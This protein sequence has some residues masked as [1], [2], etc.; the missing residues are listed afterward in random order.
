MGDRRSRVG[1]N[2]L[3]S[4][5]VDSW[6]AVAQPSKPAAET[7]WRYLVAAKSMS[8]RMGGTAVRLLTGVN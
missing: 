4:C 8:G 2:S 5:A 3:S 1:S 6:L 7:V